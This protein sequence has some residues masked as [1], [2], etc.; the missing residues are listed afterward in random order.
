MFLVFWFLYLSY[1]AHLNLQAAQQ[2]YTESTENKVVLPVSLNVLTY[3]M[4]GT[5]Q[6]KLVQ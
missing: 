6:Q 4:Q 3:S 5:V 1:L 2:Q